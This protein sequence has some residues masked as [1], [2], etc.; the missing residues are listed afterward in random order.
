MDTPT[1]VLLFVGLHALGLALWSSLAALNNLQDF[2]GAAF[3]VG[4]TLSMAALDVPPV[5]PTP[6][7]RRAVHSAGLH[8]AALVVVLVLQV[9]AAVALWTGCAQLL[10][11][12]PREA[13]LPWLNLGLVAVSAALL[14]ML[15]G[16]MAMA[17]WVRE[18]GLQLTHLVLLLWTLAAFGLFNLGWTVAA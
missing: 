11:G 17:Y 12:A 3:A 7:R 9:C 5:I 13:V 1:T 4:R 6:L 16:G 8:R 14:A 15:L 10:L 18:E 2:R